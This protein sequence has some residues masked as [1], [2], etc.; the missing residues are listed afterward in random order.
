MASKRPRSSR[1]GSFSPRR[2]LHRVD[3]TPLLLSPSLAP[4]EVSKL[5]SPYGI[6]NP[7]QADANLQAM[8][9]DPQT[10]Q[11][12]ANILGK[13]LT[14]IAETADPDQALNEWERYLQSGIHGSQLFAYFA[15][16]PKM[17]HLLCVVFGNSPAMAHT[18]MRDPLVIYWLDEQKVLRR[19]GVRQD[20]EEEL[21]MTLATFTTSDLKLDA[22]RRFRRREFLRI[23]VR[24]LLRLAKIPETVSSLSDLAALTIHAAYEIVDTEMKQRY[25]VPMHRDRSGRMVETD[26]VVI[27]MGKLGGGELNYSSDVDL[28]YVY[29][30][31]D[32]ETRTT[33]EQTSVPNV[34]YF[35][36]LARDLTRVLSETTQ[37]GSLFR[38]DLRLRPEGEVGAL[39]RSLS[40]YVRYY[41]TRGRVWERLALLKA[42]PV[43]GSDKLGGTFLDSVQPFVL[44][45]GD[46]AESAVVM[47]VLALHTQIQA[48]MM[49]QGETHRNVKLGSGGIREIEFIVQALQLQHIK[50]YPTLFERSTLQALIRLT[51]MKL[52]ES[53]VSDFLTEAYVFLRDIEHKLQMVDELQTHTLPSNQEEVAK[54]AIRLGYQKDS[55]ELT[56]SP[57]LDDYRR[58]AEVVRQIFDRLFAAQDMSQGSSA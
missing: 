39:T 15:Q 35:E 31:E 5:L 53:D 10:R 55:P 42:R 21:R 11:L 3:P 50:G 13:L 45:S 16:A 49:R 20:I 48:R 58:H 32:G 46:A 4:A 1:V 38:V 54:C 19:Q 36:Y 57:L 27:G 33:R 40:D 56:A 47:G 6:Q 23:G 30:S 24:D 9:G 37:E 28:M 41:E 43:A 25:G 52:L 26:F 7:Q 8:A 14:Y 12:L 2:R 29:N 44:G 34:V 18:F 22:L 17:L 51:N